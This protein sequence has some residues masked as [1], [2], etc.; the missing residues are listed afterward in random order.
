MAKTTGVIGTFNGK[1]GAAVFANRRGINYARAYQPQVANP[2][3]ARQEQS[4]AKMAVAVATAKG[5]LEFIRDGFRLGYPTY[6]MQRAVGIMIPV[7]NNIISM[8][9]Q[10][11]TIEYGALAKALSADNMGSIGYDTAPSFVDEGKVAIEAI[12]P[13]SMFYDVDGTSVGCGL[14]V[15]V[16]NADA[17]ASV[18]ARFVAPAPSGGSS[19]IS[20]NVFVPSNWSGMRVQVYAFAKQIP[21]AVNGIISSQMPWKF[22]SRTSRCEYLGNGTIA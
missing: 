8:T 11:V 19:T 3:S 18:V 22:P 17:G 20:D 21:N 7:E 5:M 14:E 15:C 6:Q 4:R 10:S 13:E 1:L 9:G 16:Y 12:I 2:K